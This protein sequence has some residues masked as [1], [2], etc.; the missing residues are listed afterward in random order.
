MSGQRR[1]LAEGRGRVALPRAVALVAAGIGLALGTTHLPAPINLAQVASPHGADLSHVAPVTQTQ[2][3]C[4]GPEALGVQ[5][6]PDASAQTVSVAAVGAPLAALPSGF[7]TS[8]GAGSL[9]LSGLPLG[10]AWGPPATAGGHVIVGQISDAR[11]ALVTGAGSM[12]PGA[13]ATQWSWTRKGDNRGLVTAACLPATASSWLIAGGAAPGRLEHLVL[14][15]PGQNSVTVDLGVFGAKGR[16]TSPDALGLVVPAQKRTVVLLNAIAGSEPSPAVHVST[17]GGKVAAYL[18]DTWLDGV[19]PRGGDDVAPVAAPAREQVIAGVPV[20]GRAILRVAVPGDT[21]AVVQS[22]VLT[23]SGPT[24]L[25]VGGVTRV[26]GGSTRDIDLSSLP[27]GAYAVQVIADVPVL[28]AAMVERSRST[29][30]P[31]DM[32]WS[33]ATA[34]I[35]TLAGMALPVSGVKGLTAR[36]NLAATRSPASVRVTTVAAGGQVSTRDV[37]IGADAVSTMALEGVSSVWVTPAAGTVRAAVLTS[38][39]DTAGQLL[40]VT[41]LTDLT[42]VTTPWPLRQMRD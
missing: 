14:A 4:P 42:L 27:A 37:A 17:R 22:R 6:L 10:G 1:P 15:N 8:P 25:A 31:S 21:E 35:K 13:V 23:P 19:V 32:A 12:A 16:I 5:G 11:S 7:V 41:P 38:A 33:C 18:N 2:S 24:P 36:L 9:T 20:D 29:L 28:A 40:S 26:A 39:A 34:P 30:S 3:I